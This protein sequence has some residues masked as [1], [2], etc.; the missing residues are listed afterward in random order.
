[1]TP[2]TASMPRLWVDD[3]GTGSSPTLFAAALAVACVLHLILLLGVSFELPEAKSDNGTTRSLEIV[4]LR[5]AA[6]TEEKPEIADAVAQADRVGGGIAELQDTAVKPGID[7]IPEILEP[8]PAQSLPP[9]VPPPPHPRAVQPDGSLPQVA[10]P[11]D[12]LTATTEPELTSKPQG[13]AEPETESELTRVPEPEPEPPEPVLEPE[14]VPA[15]PAV[16]AAQILA[17]RNLEIAELTTRIQHSSVAYANRPRRKAISASTR[18]Y[19]YA[20]YLEAWRRKVERVGNLNYPD[21]AKRHKMYGNLILHAAVRA[22]GSVERVRVLRSSGFEVLDEAAVRIVELAAPYAP[23][24]PDI[25]TETDILDIT[26][27]WQF[28]SSNRLG[29]EN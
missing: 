11:D 29:W 24:P 28:L 22:D 9:P 20:N 15:P 23:F 12:R 16:T 7:P 14:P 8:E 21:E 5:Q 1:M 2:T 3:A 17:S 25:R 10:V 26:R 13:L 6:P 19:K 4:V 27:T 18:E